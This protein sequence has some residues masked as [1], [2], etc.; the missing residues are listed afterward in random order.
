LQ[1][2]DEVSRGGSLFGGPARSVASGFWKNKQVSQSYKEL[3]KHA[4][5]VSLDKRSLNI[6][7]RKIEEKKT[8][9]D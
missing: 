1:H 8:I 7:T 3:Q 9:I 5:P 6:L 4:D 2:N